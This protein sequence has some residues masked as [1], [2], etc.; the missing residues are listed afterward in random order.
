MK[1]RAW[2]LLAAA[3][4]LAGC[5][6]GP[7]GAVPSPAPTSTLPIPTQPSPAPTTDSAQRLE[8]VAAGLDPSQLTIADVRLA[9]AGAQSG[10]EAT[11][12]WAYLAGEK[13]SSVPGLLD[14]EFVQAAFPP[15]VE[16][17]LSSTQQTAE[18]ASRLISALARNTSLLSQE[19]V[20]QA[21]D[22][23]QAN[24]ESRDP[25]YRR[26][27]ANL[28]GALIPRLDPEGANQAF[29]TLLQTVAAW[30]TG[31]PMTWDEFIL[32]ASDYR[33]AEARFINQA[34]AALL[35]NCAHITGEE[36]AKAAVSWAL[37]GMQNRVLSLGALPCLAAVADE[38]PEAERR[39]AV[40]YVIA[41]LASEDAW[42]T[43]GSGII[44]PGNYANDAI[45]ILLPSLERQEV[46]MAIQAIETQAGHDAYETI[47]GGTLEALKDRY[48]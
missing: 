1:L 10:D 32:Q 46:E 20:S 8:D 40:A 11:R 21:R 16:D 27:G 3:L 23:A 38:L 13:L 2:L 18:F 26:L 39:E 37:P 35:Y 42:Y 5:S 45:R 47:F 31:N 15:A 22:A 25:E 14:R 33:N 34:I 44:R 12:Q 19:Q 29:Q 4:L 24:L 48:E 6:R 7:V 9:Q 28:S 17:T 30:Q 36:Q 43:L 41:S